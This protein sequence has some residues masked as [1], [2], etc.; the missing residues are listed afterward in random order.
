MVIKDVKQKMD[1]KQ[2][3]NQHQ[4][5][6]Q[7]YLIEMMHKILSS[8][9]N[10]CKGEVAAVL[11]L[12]VD[13]KSAY[14]HQCHKLGIENF[15]RNGVRPSLIPLLT[16]YIQGRKMKV[17]FNGTISEIR[18]QP[19]S[20]AQ[21]ATLGNQEFL[22]Q[23]NNNADSVPESDRF[24]FVDDLTALEKINLLSIG[25][26]SHNF[27]LQVASDIPM[28]GQIVEN[29]QLKSQNYLNSI[30]DWTK[31][32]KMLLNKNKTKAMIVNFTEKHQF[33]TRLQLNNRNIQ[34]VDNMKI[35]GTTFSNKLDWTLN[36]KEII[37][38]VNK[39]M[40]FLRKIAS[41]GAN[42]QEMVHLWTIY[43]RSVLEQSAVLWQGSLTKEN[44]ETLERTQKT[45]TK[46]VLKRNFKTYEE[47]LRK[48]NLKSLDER[49]DQLCLQW[50][51][52]C[53]KNEKKNHIYFLSTRKH[54]NT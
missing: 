15:M 27:K 18:S 35:L 53:I 26:A 46:L 24:K 37:T 22:S 11:C 14:S 8:V 21:G 45:F 7:H 32:Q 39:R 1:P 41:F 29:T 23:T 43:C 44:R 40:V 6:I 12:F 19:G 25:L 20:G 49:R 47:A 30:R 5:S 42:Q 48:L 51:R 4:L 16:N 52:K 10:S 28:H 31:N 36:C 33:S 13:W 38:K 34:V 2:Y 54:M 17:K 3:G 9:D 50:A